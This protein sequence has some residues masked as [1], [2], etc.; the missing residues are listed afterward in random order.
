MTAE[1]IESD[2]NAS[3]V[4]KDEAY[5]KRSAKN[6]A[7]AANKEAARDLRREGTS[8]RAKDRSVAMQTGRGRESVDKRDKGAGRDFLKSYTNRPIFKN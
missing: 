7:R 8:L 5:W 3:N 1:N 2:P 4:I 6:A